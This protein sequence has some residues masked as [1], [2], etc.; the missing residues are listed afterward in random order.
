LDLLGDDG[1]DGA[2]EG[3]TSVLVLEHQVDGLPDVRIIS[4][5]LDLNHHHHHQ[6]DYERCGQTHEDTE[7]C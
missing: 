4:S 7:D 6:D 1:S 5:C 3:A 2:R